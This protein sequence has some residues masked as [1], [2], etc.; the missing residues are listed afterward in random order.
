MKS[1][2]EVSLAEWWTIIKGE[3]CVPPSEISEYIICNFDITL[4]I[5]MVHNRRTVCSTKPGEISEAKFQRSRI[6]SPAHCAHTLC[7]HG[8]DCAIEYIR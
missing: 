8:A 3:L 7:T 1:E 4:I 6:Q 2:I 5:I